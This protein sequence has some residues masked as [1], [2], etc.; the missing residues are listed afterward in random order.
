MLTTPEGTE[1]VE[2]ADRHAAD[3]TADRIYADMWK[4]NYDLAGGRITAGHAYLRAALERARALGDGEVYATV[5]GF[6]VGLL[7]SLRD[8]P[9]VEQLA[10]ETY[11]R[12][13]ALPRVGSP[14][15]LHLQLAR[16]LVECGDREAADQVWTEVRQ[17]AESTADAAMVAAARITISLQSFFDGR[18]EDA[19]AAAS[20]SASDPDSS[21]LPLTAAVAGFL[22]ARP[23]HYLGRGAEVDLAFF[24]QPHRLRQAA[25][26]NVLARLGRCQEASGVR[27]RFAGIEE[28]TDESGLNVL[29]DLFEASITCG[30]MGM[31]AALYERLLPLSN[32]L[33]GTNLVSIGRLLG[34]AA[35]MLGRPDEARAS[36]QEAFELSRRVRL[37]PEVALIRLDLGELLVRHYPRERS[38]GAEHLKSAVEE[39][40]D[41][42]MLP[43]LTRVS[44]LLSE[45]NG[46]RDAGGLTP[47]KREVAD[48]IANGLSNRQIAEALVIAEGTVEVHIKRTLSKLGFRSRSQVAVWANEQR[49]KQ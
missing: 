26:A 30:D 22:L 25:R 8:R 1:W 7:S 43:A 10:R 12:G 41:M 37:R 42:R 35:T 5:S 46:A 6:G 14:N 18:L 16:L 39:L 48:L 27:A 11:A 24:S 15:V 31:A 23:L 2:R 29:V 33:H 45:I 20:P 17:L 40:R 32:R 3:N 28:S 36:M 38:Q 13:R 4:G 19:I 9:L 49:L 21:N 44:Q 47:R 34:E